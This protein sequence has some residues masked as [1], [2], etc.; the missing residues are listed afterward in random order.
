MNSLDRDKYF[1]QNLSGEGF[2]LNLGYFLSLNLNSFDENSGEIVKNL[3]N[4]QYMH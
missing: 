3:Y 4:P 1:I 2:K